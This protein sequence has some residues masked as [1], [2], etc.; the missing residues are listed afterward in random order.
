MITS[1]DKEKAFGRTQDPFMIKN[2][3]QNRNRREFS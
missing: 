1:V 3:Q 2:T